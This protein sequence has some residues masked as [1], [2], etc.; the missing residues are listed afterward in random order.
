[1]N[2]GDLRC[3][4]CKGP[5][6]PVKLRCSRCRLDI[7]GSFQ[8]SPLSGLSNDDIALAIAFIRSYGSIKKLQDALGV[9]YPTARSRLEKLVERLNSSMSIPPE[10]QTT[11]EKLSRGE[12]SVSDALESL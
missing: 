11:L 3:P 4:S 2:T 9:S 7:E 8:A 12:I 5:L 1:M 10:Q 6:K